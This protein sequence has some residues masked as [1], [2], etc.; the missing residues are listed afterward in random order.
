[1]KKLGFWGCVIGLK[2]G[3][4]GFVFP[5]FAGFRISIILCYNS[6][7]AYLSIQQIGF[8]LHKTIVVCGQAGR[9]RWFESR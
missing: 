6:S 3:L 2:L 5:V 7:C 4:I 9:H 1:M 8:V